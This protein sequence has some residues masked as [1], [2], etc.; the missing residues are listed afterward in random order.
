MTDFEARID[1]I[2]SRAAIQDL[3]SRYAQ[4]FD[5][6][7]RDL[8]R[9]VWSDDAILDLGAAGFGEPLIGIDAIMAAAEAFWAKTPRMHHWM[10]NAIVTVHGD[11]GKA[12]TALDCFVIDSVDGPTQV[13]GLYTDFAERRDS[14]W[15]ITKREFELHYWA[16][17]PN[18]TS[19]IGI[20]VETLVTP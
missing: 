20:D 16:P 6:H 13:G 5:R 2:E 18:W 17:L 10:A 4:G 3:A 1:A 9:S 7:D 12:E 8:L 14:V 15:K 11:T 19:A